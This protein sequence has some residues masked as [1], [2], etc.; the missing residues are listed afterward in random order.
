MGPCPA[1]N[2]KQQRLIEIRSSNY[3][4]TSAR[5]EQIVFNRS[6]LRISCLKPATVRKS[7]DVNHLDGQTSCV[8]DIYHSKET[9]PVIGSLPIEATMSLF[10]KMAGVR[11]S[12]LPTEHVAVMS[13]D[14]RGDRATLE[15]TFDVAKSQI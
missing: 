9:T 12:I 2:G 1:N 5:T 4:L 14:T 11:S 10:V 13:W 7:I 3:H 6:T 15:F 8:D